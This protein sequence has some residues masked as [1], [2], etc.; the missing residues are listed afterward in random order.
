[1]RSA[2][3]VVVRG[4]HDLAAFRDV[5]GSCLDDASVRSEVAADVQLAASELVTNGLTH[6]GADSV[7]VHA[8]VFDDR[9]ELKVHHGD[10]PGRS[11]PHPLG[12]RGDAGGRGMGILRHVSSH[13]T[14]DHRNGAR[15]TWVV[16]AR[17]T[18]ATWQL[19]SDRSYAFSA[20]S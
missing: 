14:T 11:R 10:R 12:R 2:V 9:I 15:T 7:D 17:P 8:V 18:A 20:A 19:P 16:F 4:V 6:G 3:S 5:L 1:M 13:L